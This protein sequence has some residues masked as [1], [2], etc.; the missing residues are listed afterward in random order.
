MKYIAPTVLSLAGLSQAKK[1]PAQPSDLPEGW[2]WEEQHFWNKIIDQDETFDAEAPEASQYIDTSLYDNS[3]D[4]FNPNLF[5]EF[6]KL[7]AFP[8]K[9]YQLKYDVDWTFND[10]SKH[11]PMVV[12]R[13][14]P[15]SCE[16]YNVE[17]QIKKANR[18]A[19]KKQAKKDQRDATKAQKA[20]DRE[21]K[22]AAR[23][24]RD[25][26]VVGEDGFA[27]Y[28]LDS[29]YKAW[30]KLTRK[31]DVVATYT[32]QNGE[33]V[34]QA[35]VLKTAVNGNLLTYADWS[36]PFFPDPQER[37]IRVCWY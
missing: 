33:W 35:T 24:K 16:M 18:K 10:G 23:Q 11:Y 4:E 7:F 27:E 34:N 12:A 5:F 2:N 29:P 36:D 1:A 13:A 21:A 31:G 37:G 17:K 14:A 3:C 32:C 8:K 20:A 25:N 30:K 19:D 26:S 15:I 9:N 28:F 22:K 6:R